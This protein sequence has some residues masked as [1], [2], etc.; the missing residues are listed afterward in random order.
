[1]IVYGPD[2]DWRWRAPL[3]DVTIVPPVRIGD[4]IAVAGLD[5]S[6]TGYDLSTGVQRWRRGVGVEIR[7]PMA[8]AADRLAVI[9]QT[10]ALSC[11]DASGHLLWDTAA[12]EAESIAITS[13]ASPVVV[14]PASGAPRINAYSLADGASTWL[15]RTPITAR[16]LIGLDG[17]VVV[18]DGNRTVAM[19]AATGA[20]RWTWDAERTYNGA[21]GAD[22]VLLVTG[23][24][25]VLLDSDGRQVRNW[26]VDVGTID[27][28]STWL[29]TS[30]GHVLLFG[31]R[32]LMLGVTG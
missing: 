22:R 29:T 12:S 17:Q 24:R 14:V 5:G 28:N 20:T 26:P 10:G 31:P 9:D 15:V 2:G 13:G 21:G 11:L 18:R 4:V 8:V 30:A 16:N 3:S 27:G 25:L 19:D 7:V 6:L 23:S 1:M 32:G